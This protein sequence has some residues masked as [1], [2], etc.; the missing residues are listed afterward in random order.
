MPPHTTLGSP[1]HKVEATIEMQWA[2]VDAHWTTLSGERLEGVIGRLHFV[3]WAYI[4]TEL[5]A[6][7][8][9]LCRLGRFNK[10]FRTFAI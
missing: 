3:V 6:F 2:L 5:V 8:F 4:G 1:F 7:P 9:I 10:D